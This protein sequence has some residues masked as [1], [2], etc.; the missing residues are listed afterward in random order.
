MIKIRRHHYFWLALILASISPLVISSSVFTVAGKVDHVEDKPLP[1]Q[2][3]LSVTNPI[4]EITTKV[5]VSQLE[6][7]RYTATLIDLEGNKVISQDE[8]L[9]LAI[10]NQDG[11]VLAEETVSI[12]ST[13]LAESRIIANL[14][15][16]ELSSTSILVDDKTEIIAKSG[17]KVT[18]QMVGS[19][20]QSATVTVEGFEEIKKLKLEEIKGG[21]YQGSYI[22]QSGDEIG[23]AKVTFSLGNSKDQSVQLSIDAKTAPTGDV[24]GDGSVN[25]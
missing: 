2:L 25:I 23:N 16:V 21:E 6:P 24:N 19:P 14:N 10:H 1:D 9:L 4:R 12:S 8:E 3:T 20:D 15:L 18:F 5:S 13:N 11:M 17:Q 22:V 7:A